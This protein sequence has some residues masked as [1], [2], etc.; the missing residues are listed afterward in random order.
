MQF[1]AENWVNL[2]LIVLLAVYIVMNVFQFSMLPR[3]E[4]YQR[5]RG[6]LLQ[7]VIFAEKEFGGGTGNLKLS[8]VYAE[9]CEQLPWMA[10]VIPFE[11]FC[12][13]VDDALD[14]MKEMLKSNKK[15]AAF[16]EGDAV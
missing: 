10:K 8:A 9:F 11:K 13:Y 5:I 12:E 4:Q 15:L 1:L 6:W 16:M 7:A 3:D 14:E 2:L